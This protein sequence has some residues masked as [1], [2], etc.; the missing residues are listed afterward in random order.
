MIENH[1]QSL[2]SWF[3]KKFP[4]I[5]DVIFPH[6]KIVKFVF[7]GG[8]AAAVTIIS[9]FIFTDLFQIWYVVSS[10]I[11]FVIGFLVSFTFQKFWTFRDQRKDKIKSQATLYLISTLINLGLNTSGIFL[12]VHYL[13][14]HYLIAQFFVGIAIACVTYFVYNKLIFNR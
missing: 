11:A 14:F 8:S 13:K 6:R 2:V 9:L 3:R 10:V 12:L 1:Y 5:F 4:K 7:S